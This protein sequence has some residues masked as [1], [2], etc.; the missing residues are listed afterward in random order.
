MKVRGTVVLPAPQTAVWQQLATPT[1]ISQCVPGLVRWETITPA[2]DY[3]L[4]VRW[5]PRAAQ[6]FDLP[7]RLHWQ[8]QHPP[9][10]LWL[11][12]Q[13]QLPQQPIDAM[14]QFTLAPHPVRQTLLTFVATVEA[15]NL[16]V[17]Q[18]LRQQLPKQIDTFFK[19]LQTQLQSAV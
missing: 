1:Q 17:Q 2:V 9:D 12:L 3:Q 16:F 6:P 4:W 7:V 14:L 5:L 10:Q 15:E 13:A 11:A 19:A 18:L 8:R